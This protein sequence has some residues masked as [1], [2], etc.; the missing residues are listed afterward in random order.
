MDTD[1]RGADQSEKRE[2][3][4]DR[5]T[6]MPTPSPRRPPPPSPAGESAGRPPPLVVA[7][8]GP[9]NGAFRPPNGPREGLAGPRAGPARRGG[10]G[11]PGGR[12]AA[13][14]ARRLTRSHAEAFHAQNLSRG[15]KCADPC[16][17]S[18]LDVA[19]RATTRATA[20]P[21][22][23]HGCSRPRCGE[24]PARAGAFRV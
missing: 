14:R 16:P 20:A 23:Y 8:H 11:A 2:I 1:S 15:P 9:R 10:A 12:R 18:R 13:S 24:G 3:S 19:R 4:E 22:G 7:S 6:P 17:A 21:T 5:L